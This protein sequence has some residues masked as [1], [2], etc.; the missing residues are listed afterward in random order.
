MRN[1]QTFWVI[2]GDLRQHWLARQLAQDGHQVHTYGLEGDFLQEEEEIQQ[3]T[4]LDGV[5]QA[6]C[7]IF[8]L[9]MGNK[10][11]EINA[12]FAPSPLELSAVFSALSPK[13]FLCGGQIGPLISTLANQ[14]GL[15]IQDYLAREE[16]VIANAVPTA[17]GCLQ[18]AMERLPTTLQGTRVLVLGYGNV[19]SATAKRLAALGAKVTVAARR[20]GQLAQA[21]ADGFAVD[22]IG[23]LLGYFCSYPCVINTVPAQLLGEAELAD[24]DPSVLLIDLASAPGGVDLQ[25]AHRLQRTVVPALSLPGKVAPASAG[26]AIKQTV[27]HMLEEQGH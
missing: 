20:Y 12:P 27:I 26:L 6:H 22:R 23:Q 17:E 1:K 25:A 24:M 16:L 7:V 19:G 9:P 14:F 3:E 18:V 4:T 2:G 11:G 5:H 21:K 10:Q 8:P 13:Q 15:T